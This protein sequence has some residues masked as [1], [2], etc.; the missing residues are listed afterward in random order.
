LLRVAWPDVPDLYRDQ[1]RWCW[2]R[3]MFDRQKPDAWDA[4]ARSLLTQLAARG[5]AE[6]VSLA[7]ATGNEPHVLFVSR[8]ATAFEWRSKLPPDTVERALRPPQATGRR[9]RTQRTNP[10]PTATAPAGFDHVAF[11][12]QH[13]RGMFAAVF[14]ACGLDADR[15]TE[16]AIGRRLALAHRAVLEAA[17]VGEPVALNRALNQWSALLGQL[18]QQHRGS[19]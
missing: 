11:I 13:W 7:H 15:D 5:P 18:R 10:P 8:R 19:F 4:K 16:N 3:F 2:R 14:R 1:L 12:A 17:R 6:A 9:P